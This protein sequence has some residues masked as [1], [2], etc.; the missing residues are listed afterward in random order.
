MALFTTTTVM[1]DGASGK[2]RK[3]TTQTQQMVQAAQIGSTLKPAGKTGKNAIIQPAPVGWKQNHTADSMGTKPVQQDWYSTFLRDQYTKKNFGE[4]VSAA[5]SVAEGKKQYEQAVKNADSG[6]VTDMR[7]IRL[8]E[9]AKERWDNSDAAFRMVLDQNFKTLAKQKTADDLMNQF[10]SAPLV[11]ANDRP[12]PKPTADSKLENELRWASAAAGVDYTSKLEQSIREVNW[13][14]AQAR[15]LTLKQISERYPISASAL[16]VLMTPAKVPAL[17]QAAASKLAG[18]E[19]DPNSAA[20][21]GANIQTGLRDPVRE[22]LA[23]RYGEE[24]AEGYDTAMSIADG[25]YSAVLVGGGVAADALEAGKS[26]AAKYTELIAQ[27]ATPKEA[28]ARA[29]V[30]GTLE[31]LDASG[32]ADEAVGAAVKKIGLLDTLVELGRKVP[33][34][35]EIIRTAEEKKLFQAGMDMDRLNLTYNQQ[36]ELAEQL[37]QDNVFSDSEIGALAKLIKAEFSE[38]TLSE[39]D[40][41]GRYTDTREIVSRPSWR[42]SEEYAKKMYP[43]FREQVSFDKNG[44]ETKY[45]AKGSVRP[46]LYGEGTSVEVKNYLIETDGQANKLVKNVVRQ[47]NQRKVQLPRDTQ[48]IVLIDTR[49]QIIPEDRLLKIQEQILTET[50]L[51]MIVIFKVK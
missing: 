9:K 38:N 46:D 28:A 5:L 17:V 34:G 43:G 40:Q 37:L 30:A 6:V 47:Y 42:E 33:G 14:Q 13:E 27:G 24:A 50:Q 15:N 3:T 7:A 2:K 32:V 39:F 16:S 21:L 4:T 41:F 35:A 44:V 19:P 11:S 48:Q 18:Q 8:P 45:G 1:E 12:F 49:G 10:W 22:R 25:L 31:L 23:V 51:G 29:G 20:Y 36:A 26:A